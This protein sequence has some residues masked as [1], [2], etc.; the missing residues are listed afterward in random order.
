MRYARFVL[1]LVVFGLLASVGAW[2]KEGEGGGARP[3]VNRI[4]GKITA[5][6][7]QSVTIAGQAKE[8]GGAGP[9]V[10]V[11]VD[12]NTK[13]VVNGEAAQ[14]SNLKVGDQVRAT[15]AD[16][17]VAKEITSGQAKK[18]EGGKERAGGGGGGE[19]E[20]KRGGEGH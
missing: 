19:G 16:D 12:A 14:L 10:T 11:T 8:G 15:Y 6:D 17:K 4:A 18:G 3:K 20:K 2:A 13:V 1:P 5:I 7:G 9:E